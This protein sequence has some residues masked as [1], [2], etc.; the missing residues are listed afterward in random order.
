MA[1]KK[2]SIGQHLTGLPSHSTRGLHALFSAMLDEIHALEARIA[3][4]VEGETEPVIPPELVA[5]AA[6]PPVSAA[7]APIPMTADGEQAAPAD[8]EPPA[9][10]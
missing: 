8:P 3:T 9:A 5:P 10:A 2:E 4:K 7:P 1:L 6:I